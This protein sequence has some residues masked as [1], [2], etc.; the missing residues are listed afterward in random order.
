MTEEST[1]SQTLEAG[2]RQMAEDEQREV[3]ALEWAEAVV[4]DAGDEA[5]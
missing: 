3:E 5:P 2:Y 1:E 4:G